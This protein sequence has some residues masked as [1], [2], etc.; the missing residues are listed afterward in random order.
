V[1]S[2]EI[3]HHI[4]EFTNDIPCLLFPYKNIFAMSRNLPIVYVLLCS[5]VVYKGF[6]GECRVLRTL[7]SG[8]RGDHKNNL[9]DLVLSG[10][11][12]PTPPPNQKQELG[13][14]QA[15]P[16]RL[17]SS[18]G[19]LETTNFIKQAGFKAR[20]RNAERQRKRECC[21]YTSEMQLSKHLK[22]NQKQRIKTKLDKKRRKKHILL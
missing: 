13:V 2:F 15:T 21:K 20:Q 14:A 16:Q 19:L 3:S 11:P 22:G 7:L 8:A 10:S 17:G 4:K 5:F 18:K 12:H 1:L 6:L 9:E